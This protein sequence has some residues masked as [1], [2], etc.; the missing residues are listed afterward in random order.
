L[1]SNLYKEGLCK[2]QAAQH[3]LF[4]KY[5]IENKIFYYREM[6]AL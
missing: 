5:L 4:Q 1:K 2:L 6:V 3:V